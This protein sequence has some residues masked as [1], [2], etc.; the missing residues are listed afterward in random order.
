MKIV[1]NLP[2]LS[3]SVSLPFP[4]LYLKLKTTYTLFINYIP[5]PIPIP[6]PTTTT[7]FSLLVIL[8]KLQL[9]LQNS[10]PYSLRYA[11]SLTRHQLLHYVLQYAILLGCTLYIDLLYYTVTATMAGYFL[12]PL[13]LGPMRH[14]FFG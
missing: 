12:A 7:T 13:H 8:E 9:H 2:F 10:F 1:P 4:I 5:I 6:I 14:G 11:P 3:L